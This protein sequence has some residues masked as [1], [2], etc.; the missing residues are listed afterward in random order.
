MLLTD[1][2]V[3]SLA[4]LVVL[5]GI[6]FFFY[7]AFQKWRRKRGFKEITQRVGLRLGEVRYIGYGL[8]VA[9]AIVAYFIFWPPSAELFAGDTSPQKPFI[10]LGFS[11][12]SLVMALLYGVVATGFCEEL[13]FR[14]LI[15]G[16]LSRRLPMIAANLVQA[17]IFLQCRNTCWTAPAWSSHLVSLGSAWWWTGKVD[18]ARRDWTTI[19]L[20]VTRLQIRPIYLRQRE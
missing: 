9:L 7:F 6:P 13:L 2:I 17:T 10:G 18:I 12:T 19:N 8:V 16:S 11:Q 20:D 14:G 1:A 15:A 5:A 3:S 4:N